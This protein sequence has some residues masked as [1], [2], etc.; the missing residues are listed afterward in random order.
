MTRLTTLIV[1]LG[2]IYDLAQGENLLDATDHTRDLRA[3][4][5]A[6]DD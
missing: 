6:F 4:Y 5:P 2:A 3:A 1:A